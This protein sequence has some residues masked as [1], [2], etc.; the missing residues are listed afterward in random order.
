MGLRCRGPARVIAQSNVGY[1]LIRRI[2]DQTRDIKIRNRAS[3][4]HGIQTAKRRG[5]RGGKPE[6]AVVVAHDA[7]V[8]V[9][10]RYA[11]GANGNS[12]DQRRLAHDDIGRPLC[13]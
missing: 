7:V 1:V 13:A 9:L 5:T 12:A 10:G 4:S 6:R 3:A 8:I 2:K 11:D